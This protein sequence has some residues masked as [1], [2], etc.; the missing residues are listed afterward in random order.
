MYIRYQV[1]L[2]FLFIL[3]VSKGHAQRNPELQNLLLTYE[4]DSS[5]WLMVL[6]QDVF[7]ADKVGVN[8]LL[9]K[10]DW[11]NSSIHY[12]LYDGIA[13]DYL[14]F[15]NTASYLMTPAA[16]DTTQVPL[17]LGFEV[18]ENIRKSFRK[19]RAYLKNHPEMRKPSPL[20]VRLWG[21]VNNGKFLNERLMAEISDFYQNNKKELYK[22]NPRLAS[23]LGSMVNSYSVFGRFH[24]KYKK[25]EEY[26]A[27][28]NR[29]VYLNLRDYRTC[30]PSFKAIARMNPFFALRKND[31]LMESKCPSATCLLMADTATEHG[32]ISVY[33]L[34]MS[35]DKMGNPHFRKEHCSH[36]QLTHQRLDFL[37]NPRYGLPLAQGKDVLVSTPPGVP[38]Y[39]SYYVL[40]KI[41][42]IE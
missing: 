28:R 34:S 6:A 29:V 14:T 3:S 36:Y 39:Y 17:I 15:R 11:S 31:G 20:M 40:N 23:S 4:I 2:C 24:N 13:S 42:S 37:R 10:Y 35:I 1:F 8:E 27:N 22:E 26:F 12:H 18:D 38:E 5:D 16:T 30:I 41:Y 25:G 32:I 19:V 33:V 21:H 7:W 9:L